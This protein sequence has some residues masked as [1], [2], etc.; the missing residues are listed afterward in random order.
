M[1]VKE[2]LGSLLEPKSKEEVLANAEELLAKMRAKGYEAKITQSPFPFS[3]EDNRIISI[4][5]H[6]VYRGSEIVAN[7]I[8]EEDAKKT[9]EFLNSMDIDKGKGDKKYWTREKRY[10]RQLDMDGIKDV[11]NDFGKRIDDNENI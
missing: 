9:I 7:I 3:R 10:T 4:T 6:P 2:S 1:I 8:T 11:F 5:Y